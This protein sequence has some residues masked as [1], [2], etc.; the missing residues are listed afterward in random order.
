MRY[1]TRS[2]A[3]GLLVAVAMGTQGWAA[4]PQLTVNPWFPAYGQAVQIELRDANTYLPATRFSRSGNT[5]T[6]EFEYPGNTLFTTRADF[7]SLPVSVGELAPGSY[8]MRGR[9]FDMSRTD[10]APRTFEQQIEVS[11]PDAAGVYVVPRLPDAFQPIAVVVKSDY[12]MDPASL[13]A[14]VSAGVVRVDY[15]YA[16][17]AP[18]NSAYVVPGYATVAS[19]K[20][21]GLS[22]G[23]YRVDAVGT[24]RRWSTYQRSATRNIAIGTLATIVEYYA[25]SLDHYFISAWPDEVALLDG[26]PALGFKRTGQQFRGW[27]RAAD[28]PQGAVPV[29]RFYAS[30]PNSHF[31]T[32]DPSEC[33]F[34]KSLEQKQRSDAQVH[35]EKFGGWQFEFVA[36]YAIPPRDGACPGDT[37]PVYR[38][39]NMRGD[40][41]DSNHRFVVNSLLRAAMKKGWSEEGVAFCSPT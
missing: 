39:Y 8:T 23:A 37:Q 13:R 22:P 18:A 40:Q 11:P 34:L 1:T 32:A 25:D 4:E 10:A 2:A 14:S 30:G 38:D 6:V 5:I 24:D 35:G 28:A 3:A 19:V 31:Y 20:V 36:F 7:G 26:S 29:C 9:L 27:L 16:G 21:A 12:Q 41:N 17:D 15:T 33:Q